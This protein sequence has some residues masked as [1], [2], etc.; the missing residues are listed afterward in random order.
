MLGNTLLRFSVSLFNLRP[1]SDAIN[2]SLIKLCCNTVIVLFNNMGSESTFS[3][4]KMLNK[5]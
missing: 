2:E 1:V 5:V 3:D 4:E